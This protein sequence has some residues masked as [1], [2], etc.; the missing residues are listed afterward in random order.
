MMS[1]LFSSPLCSR[2]TRLVVSAG[3]HPSAGLSA[4]TERARGGRGE[5][6]GGG[7]GG[8]GG[9]RRERERERER[10]CGLGS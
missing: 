8:G 1:P 3:C 9:E 2:K 6:D 4:M 5:H 10:E 7:G